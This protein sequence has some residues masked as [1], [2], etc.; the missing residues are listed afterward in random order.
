MHTWV[1]CRNIR[2]KF[3]EL[4]METPCWCPSVGHWHGGRKSMKTSGIYFLLLLCKR[5]LFPRELLYIHMNLPPNN[6]TVQTAKIPRRILSCIRE[7]V[8]LLRDALWTSQKV[9]SQKFRMLYFQ[10]ERRYRAGNLWKDIFFKSASTWW[11]ILNQKTSRFMSLEFDDVM[12]KQAIPL[13]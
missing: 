4:S 3:I 8:R 9:K 10:N 13:K 6:L 1:I 7:W 12:W 5:L 11:G 2:L